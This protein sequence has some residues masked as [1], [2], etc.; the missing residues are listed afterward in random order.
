MVRHIFKYLFSGI[1]V[2]H[3]IIIFF[4]IPLS[5]NSIPENRNISYFLICFLLFLIDL[6]LFI[7]S[8]GKRVAVF[9]RM[10]LRKMSKLETKISRLLLIIAFIILNYCLYAIVLLG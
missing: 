10:D 8:H 1:L 3:L 4:I 6:D 7:N 2:L 9:P 5:T